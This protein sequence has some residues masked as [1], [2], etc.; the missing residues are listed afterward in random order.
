MDYFKTEDHDGTLLVTMSRPPYNAVS[1]DLLEEGIALFRS[2]TDNA[3][4]G[5]IV[6]TSDGK[7]FTAGMDLKIAAA[8]DDDGRVQAGNLVNMFLASLVRVRCAF[9]CAVNGHSIGAGSIMGLA[10]DWVIAA[11]GDYAFGLTEAKAGLPFPPVP[12]AILNHT[13]DPVWRR[14][15]ALT[16][17]LLAPEQAMAA[18]LV[19]QIV[20]ADKLVDEAILRAKYLAGQR[21]FKACKRQHRQP[22]NAEIDAIFG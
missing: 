10:S 4:A 16:S 11:K 8:L 19:D 1:P 18:G 13:L 17:D 22:L 15:L 20:D 14:R 2:L 9:I 5:G 6:L 7:N 3:P 12:Q 21:G